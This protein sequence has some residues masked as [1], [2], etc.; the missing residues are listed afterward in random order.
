MPTPEKEALT[1]EPW[2]AGIALATL[3]L[4]GGVTVFTAWDRMHNAAVEDVI[5][6]TAVGDSHYVPEPKGRTGAIGLKYQGQKLDMV[7]ESKIRDARLA[8][9]GTDDSGVYSVYRP[10][11]DKGLAKDHFFMKA[12]ANEFIEV[13]EE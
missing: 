11:D 2:Q 7:S 1:I 13:T 8:R 10:A 12:Q 4:V 5:T 3:L 6:P 9:V